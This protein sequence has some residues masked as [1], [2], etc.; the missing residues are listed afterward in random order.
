[1]GQRPLI[2]L[3]ILFGAVLVSGFGWVKPGL[4]DV[5]LGADKSPVMPNADLNN[6]SQA[7]IDVS[8]KVT[9]FNCFR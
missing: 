6:F 4:A 2:V 8:E 1:M 9:L 3:G 5:K 7:F